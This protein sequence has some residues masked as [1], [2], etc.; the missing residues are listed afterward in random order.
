MEIRIVTKSLKRQLDKVVL[1]EQ[2]E[3]GVAISNN[4]SANQV[5]QQFKTPRKV[6]RIK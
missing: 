3:N 5:D 4:L 2:V 6:F 1:H